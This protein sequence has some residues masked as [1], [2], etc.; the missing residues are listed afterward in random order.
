MVDSP[1][2]RPYR[3]QIAETPCLVAFVESATVATVAATAE[4]A[5]L[6]TVAATI[7]PAA[8]ATVAE[9]LLFRWSGIIDAKR[10]SVQIF[11]VH[12]RFRRFRRFI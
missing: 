3:Q 8:L 12:S 1:L 10:T 6:A 2:C 7:E 5:A 9:W 4:P 11:A